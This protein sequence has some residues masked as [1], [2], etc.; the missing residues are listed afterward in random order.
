MDDVAPLDDVISPAHV[1]E[2]L[3]PPPI[4]EVPRNLIDYGGRGATH[5]Y[6]W[7]REISQKFAEL[8]RVYYTDPAGLLVLAGDGDW[9]TLL[10][11]GFSESWRG[12]FAS[13]ALSKEGAQYLSG[14]S[15]VKESRSWSTAAAKDFTQELRDRYSVAGQIMIIPQRGEWETLIFRSFAES[16]L[17][18]LQ[19]G[20]T[21]IRTLRRKAMMS[22]VGKD[23]YLVKP[24]SNVGGSGAQD[25]TNTKQLLSASA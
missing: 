5:A 12:G 23:A 6:K 11:E 2:A 20:F 18:G 19:A 24:R 25:P 1:L 13:I 14:R 21:E 9:L 7:S 10:Q 17:E 15:V 22:P 16:Y 4:S 3:P 8:I